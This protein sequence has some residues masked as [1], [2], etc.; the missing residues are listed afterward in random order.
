[1]IFRFVNNLF[2]QMSFNPADYI[3]EPAVPAPDSAKAIV[4]QYATELV[5][6]PNQFFA[7]MLQHVIDFGLKLLVAFLIYAIGALIIKWI[8]GSLNRLFI[9]RKTEPTVASFTMSIVSISLTILLIAITIGTLGVN[10]TSF[11][12]LLAAGG[13]AVGMAMSGTL[14]N[15]AGGIMILGFKPFK[16][17][18][19]IIT[20]GYEGIVMEV[21]I[22]STKI[23]TFDN[24]VIVMP[25][26][27]LFNSNIT[28]VTNTNLRRIKWNI[29]VA[30]GTDVDEAKKLILD[31]INADERVLHADASQPTVADP[32][33]NLNNMKDS[34]IE[35]FARAW[36]TVGDYWG[37]YFSVLENIYRELPK[38]GIEFP[39]PQLD[40]HAEIA[41]KRDSQMN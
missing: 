39:F 10:T 12:A 38:H 2:C 16:A 28:N 22:V 24:A 17:G 8:K 15:F 33:V 35:L 9:K 37:V 26:G 11:A 6:N 7:D 29:D 21:N 25:N 1:M 18:D 40:V 5:T 41:D 32:A 36:S 30:Y 31:I 19:H 34:S 23:R 3:Q 4:K 20:Q 13:M 14:Q 27:S